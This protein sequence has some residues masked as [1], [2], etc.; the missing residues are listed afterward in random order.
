MTTERNPR[1]I[2]PSCTRNFDSG[3]VT[4]PESIIGTLCNPNE[5]LP[6]RRNKRSCESS[7]HESDV[8]YANV[9]FPQLTA[10]KSVKSNRRYGPTTP[11]KPKRS[12]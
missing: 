11:L 9:V 8:D 12:L 2:E 7:D 10:S 3:N 5:P 6:Q 1:F 4:L